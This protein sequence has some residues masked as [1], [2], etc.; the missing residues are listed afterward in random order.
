MA[1]HIFA[2]LYDGPRPVT[3]NTAKVKV[4]HELHERVSRQ[5]GLRI[6]DVGC[7]GLQP[8]DF[9]APLLNR[10]DFTLTGVDVHGIAETER[11]IAER[12]WG[13]KVSVRNVSA[14]D[15]HQAFAAA[16]FDLFVATQVLEHIA[17]PRRFF[18]QAARL[19]RPG[20]E[21]FLTLDSAHW[22]ARY[23]RREPL[24][25]AKNLIKKSL[26]LLGHERHY[27]LP[28]YDREVAAFCRA[29]GLE[30]LSIRYYNLGGL[31]ALHN[32]HTADQHKNTLMRHWFAVEEALNETSLA[33]RDAHDMFM[34]LYV[35]ARK[36]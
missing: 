19:L 12:G 25:L 16:S 2:D 5:P 33:Q 8:L 26:S 13:A 29:A 9:W 22:R 10:Y 23:D 24:R 32:H 36:A 34:A 20:G 30:P 3:G 31:K 14:Y 18:A 21:L 28:W 4:L 7:V 11:L 17:R 15:L 6:L 27:D 1:P 35:H